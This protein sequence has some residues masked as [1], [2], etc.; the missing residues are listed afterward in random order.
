MFLWGLLLLRLFG[1]VAI[2][3]VVALSGWC[4]PAEPRTYGRLQPQ[5]GSDQLAFLPPNLFP[6]K[7]QAAPAHHELEIQFGVI[8]TAD[9]QGYQYFLDTGGQRK[10]LF[11]TKSESDEWELA[12]ARLNELVQQKEMQLQQEF[13]VTFGRQN[14]PTTQE[15]FGRLS[16]CIQPLKCRQPRLDELY[17][18]EAA[19]NHSKPSYFLDGQHMHQGIKFLF[20]KQTRNGAALAEWGFDKDKRPGIFVEP[21]TQSHPYPTEQGAPSQIKGRTIEAIIAHE[22]SHNSMYRMGWDPYKSQKW[23]FAKRIG[24][25]TF[26]NSR[27]QE[28]SWVFCSTEGDDVFY[29]RTQSGYWVRCDLSGRKL[30][31]NG[32][33]ARGWTNAK[34]ISSDVM[35]KLAV[36]TPG[37]DYFVNPLEMFAEGLMMFRL[38]AASRNQ[39]CQRSPALYSAV[40]EFDQLEIDKTYGEG[41]YI[42]NPQG[43]LVRSKPETKAELV[44]AEH[45]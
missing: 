41:L 13:N 22:L 38:S 8:I 21:L 26:W 32:L 25:R 43:E 31:A 23:P 42:R 4:S 35:R 17:G 36:V 7:S 19:L 14:E 37:T 29:R 6:L 30:Q 44:A 10:L 12:E 2:G 9:G 5:N 15:G 40:S 18:L 20:M 45:R 16:H 24:W 33:P 11:T 39:L 34:I 3:M 27:L 1:T 28:Y